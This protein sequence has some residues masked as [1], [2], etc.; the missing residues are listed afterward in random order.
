MTT[1]VHFERRMKEL[2]ERQALLADAIEQQQVFRLEE[3]RAELARVEAE[4]IE[5]QKLDDLR[6]G[7][8][9]K[10]MPIG[11]VAADVVREIAEKGS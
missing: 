4:L 8:Y 10:A 6:W 5:M 1:D 9:G 11:E 7:R 3:A 2:L